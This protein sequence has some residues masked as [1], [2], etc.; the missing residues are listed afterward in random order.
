ML[1]FS[2][3]TTGSYFIN[4]LCKQ[5]EI[6]KTQTEKEKGKSIDFIRLLTKVNHDLA[7][8]FSC[9]VT[10][11]NLGALA[12]KKQMPR[13]SSRLT[14]KLLFPLWFFVFVVFIAGLVQL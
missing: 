10:D 11:P 8:N 6:M 1:A 9:K 12:G 3:N 2:N 5:I 4:S 14:K 13:I 7:L